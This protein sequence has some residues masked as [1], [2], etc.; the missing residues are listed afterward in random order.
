MPQTCPHCQSEAADSANFCPTCGATLPT[1]AAASAPPPPPPPPAPPPPPG[2]PAAGAAPP[3]AAAGSSLPAYRFDVAR[4][5]MADRIAGIA[6]I[7]LFISL[8]LSWFSVTV[9]N[10]VVSFSVSADGL[11]AHGYLYLVMILCILIV[12]YLG[13]R[14]GWGQWPVETN[15]PHFTVMLVVTLVNLVLV[16]VAFL[17]RPG[18]GWGWS[19]GAFLGLIAAIA[20]AA[21]YAVPQLR[22]KTM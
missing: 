8:F 20:A 9:G 10:S 6:T 13:L 4:W 2:V 21:P 3:S 11:T 18:S 15:V 5:S 12:A 22:A 16:L 1:A 7:V 19:F 17:S 14:A